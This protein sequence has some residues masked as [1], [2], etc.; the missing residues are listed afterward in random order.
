MRFEER[1]R[2]A[3]HSDPDTESC[4]RPSL[5]LQPLVENAIKYA[6][7]PQESGAEITIA[8]QLVGPMLR[9]TVSDTG[10]GLQSPTTDN[11][12]SGMTY[13]SGEHVSTGVGLSNRSEEHTSELQSLMRIS[14]TVFCLKTKI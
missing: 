14:Y 11:R 5:L 10:P 13:D 2:T 4:L 8:T 7:T 9:I 6:V 1:L 12:L 3:F